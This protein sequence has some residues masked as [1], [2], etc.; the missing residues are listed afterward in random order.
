MIGG[1]GLAPGV[2]HLAQHRDGIG[3][4]AGRGDDDLGVAD[5]ADQCATDGGGRLGRRQALDRDRSGERHGDGA[6]AV[7]HQRRKRLVSSLQ[8]A[9]PADA[10][11]GAA[12]FEDADHQGVADADDVGR[13]LA[14]RQGQSAERLGGRRLQTFA[15]GE[16]QVHDGIVALTFRVAGVL[17]DRGSGRPVAR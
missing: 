11:Q 14:G 2:A 8:A 16:I 13:R 4:V 9:A 7:H 3:G 12:G 1:K 10:E 6:I 17:D 15:H 5:L